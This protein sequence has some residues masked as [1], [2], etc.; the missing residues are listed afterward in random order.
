[1]NESD[2]GAAVGELA[3]RPV[4]LPQVSNSSMIAARSQAKMPCSGLPPGGRS[5]SRPTPRRPTQWW[6]RA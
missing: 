3:V 5:S 1:M 4:D 2:P 6:Y